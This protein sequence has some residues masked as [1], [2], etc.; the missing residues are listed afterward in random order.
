MDRE[1][2]QAL[3][4]MAR[5]AL[6]LLISYA[7]MGLFVFLA[8]SLMGPEPLMRLDTLLTGLSASVL[9][10][11]YLKLNWEWYGGKEK[12]FVGFQRALWLFLSVLLGAVLSLLY[13]MLSS[14]PN[15]SNF[16]Q[17]FPGESQEQMFASPLVLQLLVYCLL[18]PVSEELL[19]RALSFS[20][21]REMTE[22]ISVLRARRCGGAA[23]D[24]KRETETIFLPAFLTALLFAIYH[25]SFS[26]LFYA[27]P[28]GLLFQYAEREGGSLCFP[29]AMHG[30]ANLAALLA[31]H[32]SS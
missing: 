16:F 27:L 14:L 26:Q 19:F 9:I 23:E 22:K 25:G 17:L 1:H 7:A 20:A 29:I 21:I 6:P 18:T 32:F 15:V 8:E 12:R 11:L 2:F 31:E 28:M 4:P 3:P 24:R 5:L 30:G 13:G 10:P